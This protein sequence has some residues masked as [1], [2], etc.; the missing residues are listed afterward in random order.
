MIA[1]ETVEQVPI[2]KV[3]PAPD[4]VRDAIGDVSELAMSIKDGGI[5]QP[6]VAVQRNGH[7]EVVFGAPP[8]RRGRARR[9]RHRAGDRPRVLRPDR[10]LAM[11]VENLQRE[12]L[13]PLE[14][15]ARTSGCSTSCSCSQRDLA[16]RSARRSRTSRSGSRCSSC[17]RT[18]RRR[19]IP[20]E[21]RS[22]TPSSSRSSP[23]TRSGS[24]T[25]SSRAPGS[26]R[27]ARAARAR[28]PRAR[29][30]G[31]EAQE[32]FESKGHRDDPSSSE[33]VAAAEGR[34]PAEGRHA[35]RPARARHHREEAR[36]RG[37]P[38]DR[39]HRRR[40]QA[41]P[42]CTNRKN[43]PK[44]KTSRR[45][46]ARTAAA[47]GRAPSR[48]ADAEAA[49]RA[50]GAGCEFAGTLVAKK[51]PK[52]ALNLV[53]QTTRV[54][55]DGTARSTTANST[56]VAIWLG[57]DARTGGRQHAAA[58]RGRRGGTD[59]RVRRPRRHR[60]ASARRSR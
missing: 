47:A 21:S 59:P 18:C 31:R 30:E 4:N 43:H 50:R 6:I 51:P 19:S 60:A 46:T 45:T 55:L 54:E 34:A 13:T 23:T 57:V 2:G 42:V 38:R 7:F 36:D 52:D 16:P 48:D 25:R 49:G 33:R 1:Q 29:A 11:A 41:F 22:P 20:A 10:L 26:R 56:R 44:V 14:E 32:D 39:D 12:D 35:L 28:R 58:R 27:D 8:P 15:A 17:R 37:L 53:L 40:P 5:Q 24:S 3:K 9:R